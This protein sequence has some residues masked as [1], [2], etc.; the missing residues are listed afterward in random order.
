M[1]RLSRASEWSSSARASR[2]EEITAVTG[3]IACRF[4]TRTSSRSRLGSTSRASGRAL[5]PSPPHANTV[6]RS[7]QRGRVHVHVCTSNAFQPVVLCT[8]REQGTLCVVDC[9]HHARSQD[10]VCDKHS[11]HRHANGAGCSAAPAITHRLQPKPLSSSQ[12]ADLSSTFTSCSVVAVE[13]VDMRDRAEKLP[14][15]TIITLSPKLV[16]Q[17]RIALHHGNAVMTDAELAAICAP[18][19]NLPRQAAGASA[20]NPARPRPAAPAQ[21]RRCL[22]GP[23]SLTSGADLMGMQVHVSLCCEAFTGGE[24]WSP[25]AV[26][27]GS[28]VSVF[29]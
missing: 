28:N 25:K 9:S 2:F 18:R 22:H 21:H 4:A 20:R 24:S 15:A 8:A 27:H 10:V 12:L 6:F 14:P 17:V 16:L 19:A 7:T 29:A 11:R 1:C 13:D 3:L 26:I 5:Q 23:A